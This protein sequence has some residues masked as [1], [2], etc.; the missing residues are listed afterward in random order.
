MAIPVV[1]IDLMAFKIVREYEK[2]KRTRYTVSELMTFAHKVLT[3]AGEMDKEEYWILSSNKYGTDFHEKMSK[4][5]DIDVDSFK[6]NEE[7]YKT[8]GKEWAEKMIGWMSHSFM[9]SAT[10]FLNK[11]LKE[12]E[13]TEALQC[14]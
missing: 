4:I 12:K 3:L 1:P 8:G 10:Y 14:D 11:E 7:K 2:T 6:L 9:K 5:C 13:E